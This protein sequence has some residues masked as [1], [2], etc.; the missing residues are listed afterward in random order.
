MTWSWCWASESI[1]RFAAWTPSI[2][3]ICEGSAAWK[4][5]TTI[6]H[7]RCST[8]GVMKDAVEQLKVE[9][10]TANHLLIKWIVPFH[11]EAV[12]VILSRAKRT[13]IFE[14]SYSAQFYPYLRI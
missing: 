1:R 4:S 7:P 12:T 2:W 10:T 9:G 14:N 6:R 13:I 11:A 3:P 8:Y 5:K